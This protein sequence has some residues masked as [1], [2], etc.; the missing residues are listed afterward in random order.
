[1]YVCMCECMYVCICVNVCLYVYVW[2]YVCM[3]NGFI[4]NNKWSNGNIQKVF[5]E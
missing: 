2:M 4:S 3:Y 1:M 5:D